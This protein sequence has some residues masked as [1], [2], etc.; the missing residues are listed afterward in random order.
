[1]NASEHPIGVTLISCSMFTELS[2]LE[3]FSL[4]Q[5]GW[6]LAAFELSVFLIAA[7]AAGVLLTS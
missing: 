5:P 4:L 2:L 6:N 7:I 3:L 1:M